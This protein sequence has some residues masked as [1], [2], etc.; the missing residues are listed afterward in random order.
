MNEKNRIINPGY[1][2]GKKQGEYPQWQS[3]S[4]RRRNRNER[5]RE[6][7]SVNNGMPQHG[8][9]GKLKQNIAARKGPPANKRQGSRGWAWPIY[10]LL[11]ILTLGL[12][13]VGASFMALN[14]LIR[15]P[16]PH[17]CSELYLP[18][19]SAGK[20][21]YCADIMA[22]SETIQGILEAIAL[23]NTLPEDN[24]LRPQINRGIERWSNNILGLGELAYQGGDIEE[25]IAIAKQI[26]RSV[27]V[28]PIV[29]ERIDKWETTWNKAEESYQKAEQNLQNER[30]HDAYMEAS[31]LL[32]IPNSYWET[33]KYIELTNNIRSARIEGRKLNEARDLGEKGGVENLSDAIKLVQGIGE[34]SHLYRAANKVI[35]EFGNQILE[36]ALVKLDEGDWQE[37]I[38]IVSNVPQIDRLQEKAED[39]VVLAR[40]H[41]PAE[42][43]TVASIEDAISRA[44]RITANRP[45]YR[46]ARR[47]IDRWQEEIGDV[48]TIE[49]GMKLAQPGKVR[50]LRAAIALMKTI[51]RSNPR[52]EEARLLMDRWT[53][54]VER[55]EDSPILERADRLASFGDI[56]S[57]QRAIERA[58][59]IGSGRALYQEARRRIRNWSERVE[60]FEDQPLL[61]KAQQLAFSGNLEEAIATASRIRSGRILYNEARS[62]IR[63]WESELQADRILE[64]ANRAADLGTANAYVTGIMLANQVPT[65]NPKRQE[66]DLAISEWSQ[67]ILLLAMAQ[68]NGGYLQS[69]IA[70]ANLVPYGTS[71]Y[72]AAQG[73]IATWRNW[74][75][76]YGASEEYDRFVEE[77]SDTE[78]QFLE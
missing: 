67:Q 14:E 42:I 17:D 12:M 65:Y 38:R 64:N 30:W 34:D 63:T 44:Q 2:S 74:L 66:A 29:E 33:T 68:A 32:S 55:I 10:W 35:A 11:W 25:A 21:L 69:A 49:Q 45:L 1:S 27:P 46:Q 76:D 62:Q 26:P 47:L 28:Y 7:R 9:A 73:Q 22:S 3:Q 57:L 6:L 53:S 56:D 48:A 70:T 61:D 59:Q 51:P 40:A 71:A 52:A 5:L 54:N 19:T 36:L 18:L 75:N 58:S 20:R 16:S 78:Y 60:R 72:D 8:S 15:L 39:L 37:A 50:D 23:V 41:S 4:E 31:R 77:R 13:P 24:P 43:G